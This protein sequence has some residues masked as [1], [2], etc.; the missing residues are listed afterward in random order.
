MHADKAKEAVRLCRQGRRASSHPRPTSPPSSYCP[1]SS[2]RATYYK[3]Y[4]RQVGIPSFALWRVGRQTATDRARDTMRPLSSAPSAS[5]QVNYS[6]R[7]YWGVGIGLG[8]STTGRWPGPKGSPQGCHRAVPEGVPMS[9]YQY[10]STGGDELG[11]VFGGGLGAVAVRTTGGGRA[12]CQCQY[13]IPEGGSV[14][15]QRAEG[16]SVSVTSQ[17]TPP[18][19]RQPHTHPWGL[20][21]CRRCTQTQLRCCPAR[22]STSTRYTGEMDCAC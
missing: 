12:W 18:L 21:S 15:V 5:S 1:T 10:P 7:Q 4:V 17:I 2:S 3:H 11:V 6:Q 22:A 9:Q 13:R 19:S 16:V 14:S 8:V 20:I